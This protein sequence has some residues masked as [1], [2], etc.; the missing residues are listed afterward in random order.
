MRREGLKTVAS[1]LPDLKEVLDLDIYHL[2]LQTLSEFGFSH[3][4]QHETSQRKVMSYLILMPC[5]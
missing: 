2:L 1:Y 5:L 3:Q 4:A